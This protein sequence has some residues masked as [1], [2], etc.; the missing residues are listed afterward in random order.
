MGRGAR[1]TT[2][3][4]RCQSDEDCDLLA[5]FGADERLRQVYVNDHAVWPGGS[6]KPDA[7]SQ[8]P[9]GQPGTNSSAGLQLSP[10]VSAVVHFNKGRN[11][12][13]F[14]LTNGA[15]GTHLSFVLT[16]LDARG[17]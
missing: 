11:K 16:S 13:F 14:K 12:V 6:V 10:K 15:Q 5:W 7:L 1:S 9:S 2:A 8:P 17:Q 3:T 4:R